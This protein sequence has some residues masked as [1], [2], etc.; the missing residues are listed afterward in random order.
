MKRKSNHFTQL[1]FFIYL[2]LLIW[3]I[4]FKLQFSMEALD[5]GR[6]LNLIPFHYGKGIGGAYHLKE[7]LDNVLI[8]MPMGILPKSKFYT[9]LLLIAGTSLC[10][11]IAQY[12]LAV[13]RTDITDLITNTAGG[14]LGLALY[15]IVNWLLKDRAKTDKLFFVIAVVVSVLFVGLLAV[16]LLANQ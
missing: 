3:I 10:L 5:R 14:F 12:V 1:L 9:K 13:G 6:A 7:M 4:L 2:L 8:F 11:E 15:G 16:T